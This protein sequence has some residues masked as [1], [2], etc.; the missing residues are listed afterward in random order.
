MNFDD[1]I[2]LKLISV[3]LD[4]ALVEMERGDLLRARERLAVIVTGLDRITYPDHA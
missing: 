1:K 4:L 3:Q 2:T